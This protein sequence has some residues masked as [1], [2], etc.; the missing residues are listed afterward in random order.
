MFSLNIQTGLSLLS[1]ASSL[2]A[3]VIAEVGLMP[4]LCGFG[5]VTDLLVGLGLLESATTRALDVC[6]VGVGFVRVTCGRRVSAVRLRQ[7]AHLRFSAVVG[8]TYLRV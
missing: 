3:L 8:W 4:F 7:R 1:V 2:F 6:L 5:R